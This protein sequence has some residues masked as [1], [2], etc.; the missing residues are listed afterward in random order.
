MKRTGRV[1]L[2]WDKDIK[3]TV[4]DVVEHGKMIKVTIRTEEPAKAGDKIVGRHG[5]KGTIAKVVPMAEMPKAADGTNIDIIIN[6]I[7]VPSRMNIGQILESSA[8][9]IA[10]KTGKPFVVDNFDGTDYLKKIKSEMKQLGIVDKHKVID[11][12]V[13]ELENPVFIGKQ[14]VLK[15]QH[16]TGKKF[17]ARGQGPYTMDEQPAR[18]GDKS[19]Q[20]LD[21]LTNYTLL[22]HGAKE[23]LREMSIIKGQRNDE[24]W[25]EF[26]AGR[27]TPPPPTP[28]VFDKFMHNLQALGVS[29]KKDEEKFQLMAMTDKEIEEMSS[30]KIEDARLIKAP[31]LAPEKGGLFDPDA[32]G[33]PGGS[34]WSHIELA[35]PIPNPVFKD[36]IISLLDMTTK[37]FESVL[38]GEKYI[39]GKTGGQAIEDALSKINVKKELAEAKKLA[40]SGEV[41][42]KQRLDNF[43]KIRFLDAL[44][45]QG[46]NQRTCTPEVPV[47]PQKFRPI[48]PMP[49]GNLCV[50]RQ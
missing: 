49:D 10:E 14:Y 8:A 2:T 11:P 3:G 31:D 47:L 44:G 23:N 16:Q 39:N 9:L 40:T 45:A 48:Y 13:G 30:G 38:K 41:R 42:S 34:K 25:R 4:V 18:G 20:A 26:R 15:L 21:V 22:A 27:P 32:T 43:T 33:G 35:E 7:A 12:E 17:S 19:G 36:A 5:N 1:Y 6:P 46:E 28:F 29:V 37:E 50:G 24:Y